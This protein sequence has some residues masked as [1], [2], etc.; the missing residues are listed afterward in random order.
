[1]LSTDDGWLLPHDLG[2][3]EPGRY[4]LLQLL[5]R[6]WISAKVSPLH[7]VQPIKTGRLMLKLEGLPSLEEVCVEEDVALLLVPHD[8][9][10]EEF[11]HA[12]PNRG[13]WLSEH[14]SMAFQL[15]EPADGET[16]E[17]AEHRQRLRWV[18]SSRTDG[19]YPIRSVWV[20][21]QM[22]GGALNEFARRARQKMAES[23]VAMRREAV[24][25]FGPPAAGKSSIGRLRADQLAHG[26]VRTAQSLKYREEVNN[27]NLTDCMPGFP[28]EYKHVLSIKDGRK[29]RS[30]KQ[31]WKK[32]MVGIKA[33][34]VGIR[35]SG[36]DFASKWLWL[37]MMRQENLSAELWALQWLTYL[38]Y[39][40]GPV[41]DS[42]A[43]DIIKVTVVDAHELPVFYSSCMA[44]KAMGRAMMI[45]DLA[46]SDTKPIRHKRLP[47]RGF[48]PYT[49]QEA[50]FERQEGRASLERKEGKLLGGN[51]TSNLVDIHYHAQ[52]AESNI[53]KLLGC[54]QRGVRAT[55]SSSSSG[56]EARADC[57]QEESPKRHRWSLQ[58]AVPSPRKG[59]GRPSEE[60]PGGRSSSGQQRTHVK[61]DH[62]LV[63]D[64][65][66]EEPE[67]LLDYASEE[68]AVDDE[69]IRR[70]LQGV[71]EEAVTSSQLFDKEWDA[72][73][74]YVFR[75]VHFFLK[76]CF[77][78]DHPLRQQGKRL[79][80][81]VKQS[82][83]WPKSPTQVLPMVIELDE[84]VFFRKYGARST[85]TNTKSYRDDGHIADTISADALAKLSEKD[86]DNLKKLLSMMR[87]YTCLAMMQEIKDSGDWVKPMDTMDTRSRSKPSATPE[88]NE[89][90]LSI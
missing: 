59:G 2:W 21:P 69:K 19:Q 46:H 8:D 61:V 11:G 66:G 42:L 43:L 88:G 18:Q 82:L 22:K 60:A 83:S 87:K 51:L 29:E 38:V 34:Q 37:Q 1:M 35:D 48:W 15:E 52:Q 71:V 65:E 7:A 28:E 45:L 55:D 9:C 33:G 13:G 39:H 84:A 16:Q 89:F 62:F 30:P 40:H 4:V 49:S 63:I 73:D 23:P 86:V 85:A 3:Q 26:L 75:V 41:R 79:K 14:I 78:Q 90:K 58:S 68:G 64:N 53:I 27:D 44:G 6:E 24:M 54:L 20:H 36:T 10:Q 76:T 74:P 50:R 57:A 12:P 56:E 72:F 80:E 77:P 17:Q 70:E 47:F 81:K 32:A 31:L 25:L 67:V 5:N